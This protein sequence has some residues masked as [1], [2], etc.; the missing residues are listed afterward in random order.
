VRVRLL[1]DDANTTPEIDSILAML[2]VQPNVEVRLYNPF[3][4]R[5]SKVLGYLGDFER[6]NHRMHNK[7]YTVDNQVT[8][9]GGRNLAD[10]YFEAEGTTS[11]ADL[12][13]LA[14]GTV[15]PAV[16][17]E[18]DLFWNSP[19]AYPAAAILAGVTPI[20]ADAF[21]G[22][23]QEEL[24]KPSA[25]AYR[26]AVADTRGVQ[27]L[28]DGSLPLE[29]TRATILNDDPGKTLAPS[30]QTELQLLPKLTAALG[31]PASS[32]DLISPYF[33]PGDAG[34]T[35]L[36]AIAARGVRV[37]VLTNSLAATDVSPA[38]AG[39]MKARVA[40]LQAGVQLYELKPTAGTIQRHAYQIGSS[41]KAGLHAKTYAVDKRRIFVG[42]F[43]LDPRSSKLNTEMGMLIESPAMAASLSDFLDKA[44]PDIAYEV[45]LNPDGAPR[46]SDGST[47]YDTE[48]ATSW[49]RRAIVRFESWL[50][51][52][53][54]L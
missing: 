13:A 20:G 4:G 30:S 1:L 11:L 25:A 31:Q 14:V 42:S 9:V 46:W 41:A 50:P 39:Y 28:L 37:R 21:A 8:V 26:E 3:T 36:S 40:L 16:S 47:V 52:D 18:F 22:H 53:W 51:I 19:S 49:G 34:V 6:L 17:A 27:E 29:W 44:F 15:V 10:E 33:V 32:L 7:S 54:L 35:A 43:N 24:G 38:H 23:L 45:T 5:G 48:P 2:M 12:D